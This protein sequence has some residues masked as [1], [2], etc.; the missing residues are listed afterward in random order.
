MPSSSLVSGARTTASRPPRQIQYSLQSLPLEILDLVIY[1]LDRPAAIA[2]ARVSPAFTA[3]AQARIWRQVNLSVNPHYGKEPRVCPHE[4]ES[5]GHRDWMAN[6]L[7]RASCQHDEAMAARVKTVMLRADERRLGTIEHIKLVSRPTSVHAVLQFLNYA[8]PNLRSLEIGSYYPVV[9]DWDDE[10]LDLNW[11]I[12]ELSFPLLTHLRIGNDSLRFAQTLA[13]IT[14][15]APQL[16]SLD[17]DLQHWLKSPWLFA[18]PGPLRHFPRQERTRI[19]KL[20]LKFGDAPGA[21][22]NN[23]EKNI[24]PALALLEHCPDL[25]RLTIQYDGSLRSAVDR[26]TDVIDKHKTLQRLFWPFSL[27]SMEAYVGSRESASGLTVIVIYTCDW[28]D[29]VSVSYY[30]GDVAV[31]TSSLSASLHRPILNRWS[32]LNPT[33]SDHLSPPSSLLSLKRC[34]PPYPMPCAGLANSG[35]FRPSIP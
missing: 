6:M 11:L 20:R 8:S 18:E 35:P 24:E 16:V 23:T 1:H 33:P 28:S 14:R 7:Y 12:R 27:R 9:G 15:T 30:L 13:E 22:S 21:A 19:R 2:L 26:V 32:S 31:L 25:E 17:V 4:E 3:P 34:F 5:R 29:M 10:T